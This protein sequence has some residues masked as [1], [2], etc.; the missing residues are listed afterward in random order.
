MKTFDQL[1][2]IKT[3]R[4]EKAER[5]VR[6]QR[7]VLDDAITERDEAERTL[8]EF[9]DHASEEERRMYARL[10]ERPVLLRDIEHVQGEVLSLRQLE[11]Q[12]AHELAEAEARRD[13]EEQQLE[14]DRSTHAEARRMRDKFVELAT[15][16]AQEAR[17]EAE[18]REEAEIEEA[19][20]TR[21]PRAPIP[22]TA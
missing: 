20:E 16:F 17:M 10:C 8:H 13:E 9:R 15:T 14:Q 4:D 3:F 6:A 1:V 7:R 18:R 2:T 12:R 5:A 21:P 11:K 22:E 19:A